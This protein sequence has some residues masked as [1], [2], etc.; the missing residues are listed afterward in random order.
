VDGDVPAPLM[1][2]QVLQLDVGSLVAGTMYR[3][4]FEERLKRVIDELKKAGAILFIDEV[5]ML[6]GAGSAGSAVDAAN[7][8]KPAL[9]RGELQV[10]GATT[11]D[12][13]RKNI[14]ADAAL[15]RRFQSILV[16]EPS[17]EETIAILKGIRKAY[18]DHHHLVI[19]D[20][21]LES[22]TQLSSRYISER[23]LPDK[24][25]DLIDESSS[26]VRMYKSPAAK[27]AKDLYTELKETKAT[28]TLAQEEG[29]T[30]E[31]LQA[32]DSALSAIEEKIEKI[33]TGWDRAKSPVVS[34]E[35]I[36][37]M[38]SMW[39]GVPLMQLAQEESER[40]LHMEE[41]LREH[42]IG[43]DE[44]IE[45]IARAVRRA[46]AG[47]KDPQRPIG[48]LMFLGPT[49]VGKT[50]LTKALA[51]FMFG[52]EDAAIQLDMSEFME[53]HTASRLV[54]APPG[55]VGYDDA[56]Q[57]TEALRRRPYS[58]VVF[59]EVEKAHGEV[60]N[61]LL[62]IME[63]GH[64]SDARGQKVDFSNAIIVMTSNVGADMIKKQGS[65]GFQLKQDKETEER[66]SYEEM[67]KKLTETLKRAF[68]PE[69]INRLD[70]VVVFRALNEED[71]QE[72]VSLELAKVSARLVEHGLVLSAT[73]VA[74]RQLGDMGY[75]PEM[76]ARPL[77]RVIQQQ[78][79]DP[80]SD[81]LLTGRFAEGD[82]ILVDLDDGGEIILIKE[83]ASDK[84]ADALPVA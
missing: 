29:Q 65:L 36:A 48:S 11:M 58:I 39:T 73:S 5:H 47:L 44:A 40:L 55:Y 41:E 76:G 61:M 56:G 4:Q 82:T 67:R 62:Q 80:L 54:G 15:E 64:L 70:G 31:E 13:Y 7:I 24:A 34:A 66:L 49:G 18:E 60:H 75:D 53:R 37:E 33:R 84:E 74:L 35:D 1:K 63:E 22:A 83:V 14:E 19:S 59:D 77:K 81:A 8:L 43:Q 9:S 69:F 28:R 25:I 78:V 57:L 42:I 32:I 10:I 27:E 72:I 52:S 3:G 26:R 45:I 79:E 38:V 50:E 71:I 17:E 46:R 21:A 30:E 6:V 20:E 16:E 2:K 23:F 12:E 68:R 51:K